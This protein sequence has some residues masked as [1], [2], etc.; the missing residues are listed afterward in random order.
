MERESAFQ[1]VQLQYLAAITNGYMA[2]E[3]STNSSKGSLSVIAFRINPLLGQIQI[4]SSRYT[5]AFGRATLNILNL[6]NRSVEKHSANAREACARLFQ[7][8]NLLN[9]IKQLLGI[10]WIS[11]S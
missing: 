4:S 5:S 3:I 11:D 10:L 7:L 6:R 2:T 9:L 1:N 8:A